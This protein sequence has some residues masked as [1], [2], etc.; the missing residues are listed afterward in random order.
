MRRLDFGST[1]WT[2][3]EALLI[4][5]LGWIG[6]PLLFLMLVQPLADYSL[7]VAHFVEQLRQ[8]SVLANFGLV[9]INTAS[10]LVVLSIF[11]RRHRA[12]LADL[13]LRRFNP[14]RAA[15][16]IGG[17][18]IIFRLLVVAAYTLIDRLI[19]AFNP[20]QEQ[21][22]EFAQAGNYWISFLALVVIP[23]LVEEI[24]FRGY[25]FPALSK[26]WGVV[27]GAV[28]SSLLFGAAHLQLNVTIYTLILGVILCM[29][30]YRLGSI[31]PG[32]IFH[33]LNNYLAFIALVSPK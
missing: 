27:I 11:M 28:F 16:W 29:M 5:L 20:L 2:V 19:P 10:A 15:A 6:V 23:P 22:N 12:G 30:Y 26:R 32:I 7:L 31:W 1:K 14:W 18:L 13:G 9:L 25:L 24:V 8:G 33:S 21:T 4:F 3:R 17:G